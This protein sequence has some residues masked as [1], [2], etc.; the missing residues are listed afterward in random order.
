MNTSA[1]LP[2]I[3]RLEQG[4][5]MLISWLARHWLWTANLF[6]LAYLG[7]ALL[8]PV[9]MTTGHQLLGR[10]IYAAYSPLCHQWPD[11]SYFL[12]GPNVQYSLAELRLRLG[13][14]VTRHYVGE[15]AVGYKVAICQRCVAMY[16][17]MLVGGLLYGLGRRRERE[18]EPLPWWGVLLL[19]IPVV[20]DGGGQLIG[21]WESTW[22]VRSVTGGLFGV[23]W[24]GW[25]YPNLDEAMTEMLRFLRDS[26]RSKEGAD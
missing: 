20:F 12:F 21:L 4:L 14:E 6:C 7:F 18:M 11:R 2:R 10:L 13:T 5:R 3:R 8:A 23:A 25:V 22:G 26:S 9:L 17:V 1:P 24:V 19:L 16:G 15:S